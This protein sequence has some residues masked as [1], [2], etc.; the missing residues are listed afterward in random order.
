V[1]HHFR[2]D[3]LI[4]WSFKVEQAAGKGKLVQA[5]TDLPSVLQLDKGQNGSGKFHPRSAADVVCML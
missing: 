1:E 5:G 2:F 4:Q 3:A